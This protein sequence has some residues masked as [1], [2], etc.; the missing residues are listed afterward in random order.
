MQKIKWMI[1]VFLLCII[2]LLRA[3]AQSFDSTTVNNVSPPFPIQSLSVNP[4]A[5]D[6]TMELTAYIELTDTLHIAKIH[7]KVGTGPLMEDIG[8]YAFVFDSSPDLPDN[9]SYSR[10]GKTLIITWENLSL[11]QDF[12]F[13]AF[14]EYTQACLLTGTN[15]SLP[16]AGRY[17]Q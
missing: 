3:D 5:G 6:S 17:Q 7:F 8:T 12:Y 16:T 15:F 1:T 11:R 2:G 9:I 13:E 14:L 10:N 4:V